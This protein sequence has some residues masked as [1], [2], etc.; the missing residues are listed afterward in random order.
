MQVLESLLPA[1]E[2]RIECLV[3]DP[4]LDVG[5]VCSV[6]HRWKTTFCSSITLPLCLSVCVTVFSSMD[7]WPNR[8]VC[9]FVFCF[10]AG[11]I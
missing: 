6:N 3:P 11:V 2:T 4:D 5:T 10:E 8:K 1:W 9:G 7:N